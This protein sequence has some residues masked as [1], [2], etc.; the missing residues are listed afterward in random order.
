[1]VILYWWNQ[2]ETPSNTFRCF[3]HTGKTILLALQ[4]LR[5][6]FLGHE[7]HVVSIFFESLASSVMIQHQLQ[8]TLRADPTAAP[9]PGTVRLHLCHGDSDLDKVISDLS[10]AVQED[11]CVIVDEANISGR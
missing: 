5:W 10:S 7:V 8:E 9:T 6:L 3:L 1:M 4:G 2:L 11:M